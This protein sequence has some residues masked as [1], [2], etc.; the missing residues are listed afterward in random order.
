MLLGN[1]LGHRQAQAGAPFFG[2]VVGVEYLVRHLRRNPRAG[3]DDFDNGLL[4]LPAS[5]E[6]QLSAIVT[7]DTMIG[8]A[9][10]RADWTAERSPAAT[11]R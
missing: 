11:S 2:R 9:L 5:T 6:D 8:V 4:F 1:A 7:R 3:V 10:P